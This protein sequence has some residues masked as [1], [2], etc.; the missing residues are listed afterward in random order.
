MSALRERLSEALHPR[1]LITI[2]ITLVLVV[3]EWRYGIVGGYEKLALTLGTCVLCEVGL[4]F[5]LLGKRPS[6]IQSAYIT[7]VSLT[8]LLRPQA[9][10]V[11]PFVAGALLGI[12]SKY[13]L[14]YR[15]RHLWNPSNFA[16]AAILLLAPNRV[17]ILSHEFGNDV[18]GNAV[19][20]VFG[21]LI[22]SRARI[23]HVSL[24]YVASFVALAWVRSLAT[25]SGF[26]TEVAPLTGPMYQLMVFFMLTDPRTTV[27]TRRG[28]V[29]T[30]ALIAVG[31][32][33]IRLAN[34]LDVPGAVL[35]APAPTIFALAIIG[36]L[37]LAI[38]LYR[39]RPAPAP[40]AAPATA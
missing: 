22:A 5:F 30:V 37:A 32:A 7:G 25:G 20:W 14:R 8:M 19:I 17:A 9:G 38:D 3:G 29:I 2:L 27:S 23:L 21:L 28:R 18:A 33:L 12:G 4:S 39:K 1:T 40:A 31:E 15:G 34:D 13:V 26:L 6:T 10:I 16:I 35:F 24:T 36:P 11:W